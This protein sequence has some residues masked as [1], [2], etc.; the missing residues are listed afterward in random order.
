MSKKDEGKYEPTLVYP[1]FIRAL[2]TVRRYGIN[3][4]GSSIDWR[5]TPPVD[6]Y[7]AMGRHLNAIL[8]GEEFDS[9]SGMPH[10]WHLGA[11]VMFEVERD[12]GH[13][14]DMFTRFPR[15]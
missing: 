9:V 11:N 8:A 4:H 10:L 3:K 14:F 1:S 12:Y 7:D 15:T 5:T 2:A 13:M 6:H